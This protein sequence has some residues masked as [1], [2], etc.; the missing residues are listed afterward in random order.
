MTGRICQMVNPETTTTYV[1][2]QAKLKNNQHETCP[3]LRSPSENKK[4]K[5][6]A[7]NHTDVAE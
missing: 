1:A 4:N 7:V 3:T 6:T 2:L 5:N